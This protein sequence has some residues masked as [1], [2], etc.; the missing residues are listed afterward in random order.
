MSKNLSI[1]RAR[2]EFRARFIKAIDEYKTVA[3]LCDVLQSPKK[4]KDAMIFGSLLASLPDEIIRH[5]FM[6]VLGNSVADQ[7]LIKFCWD[8]LKPPND[9]SN[10]SIA[11]RKRPLWKDENPKFFDTIS[12]DPYR[13]RCVLHDSRLDRSHQTFSYHRE[14]ALDRHF[15]EFS[16]NDHV[17]EETM[18]PL[19]DR[20]LAG[21]KATFCAFGQ[22]GTGK[23]HT[24]YGME[25]SVANELFKIMKASD[26]RVDVMIFEIRGKQCFDLLNEGCR[27]KLMH[28]N[29]DVKV[30]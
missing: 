7:N 24:V 13:H 14:Y 30:R 10:F 6:Y 1:R 26:R 18:K 2:L 22:T 16:T 23:T 3:L 17:F 8:R 29:G 27:V 12:I 11:V 4:E 28:Q 15:D 19:L 5:I 20:A 25:T 9:E 21:G